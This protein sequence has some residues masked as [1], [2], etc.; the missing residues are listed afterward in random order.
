[1]KNMNMNQ[2]YIMD[3]YAETYMKQMEDMMSAGKMSTDAFM[4][5]GSILAKGMEDMMKTCISKA[6][7]SNEKS[8]TAW[9]SLMACKTINDVAEAQN[10]MAQQCLEEA[11][12]TTA[13]MSEMSVKVAMEFFE[14][15]NKQ[16]SAAMR[17]AQSMAA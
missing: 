12:N 6:Q 13:Q 15:I 5:S 1:M 8:A 14:P 11:M 7:S 16:M 4:K 3:K 10:R 2:A 9:K 17:K